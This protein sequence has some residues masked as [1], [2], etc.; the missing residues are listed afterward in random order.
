MVGQVNYKDGLL[1]FRGR[2]VIPSDSILR[3]KLLKKFHSSPIG[4]HVGITCTFHR[5]FSILFW[6]GMCHDVQRFVSEC[7]VCQ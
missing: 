4:G 7:Q 1:L 3:Q 2:L 6:K 5:V